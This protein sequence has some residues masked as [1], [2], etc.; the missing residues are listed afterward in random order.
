MQK[1]FCV[2]GCSI[3]VEYDLGPQDCQTIF[4]TRED[5]YGRHIKRC[6]GCGRKIDIDML[7]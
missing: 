2:C 6:F 4:W 5:R 1:R 7:R 3:W